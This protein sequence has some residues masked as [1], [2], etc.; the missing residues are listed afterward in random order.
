[1]TPFC[2]ESEPGGVILSEAKDLART[3]LGRSLSTGEERI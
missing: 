3:L 2:W 1:M